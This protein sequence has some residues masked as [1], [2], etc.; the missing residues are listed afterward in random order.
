MAAEQAVGPAAEVAAAV[1]QAE[2]A[3]VVVAAGREEEA[4]EAAEVVV[5]AGAAEGA[6]PLPRR[7][8]A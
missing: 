5:R 8:T 1:R 4:V 2:V 3:E 7:R 6:V